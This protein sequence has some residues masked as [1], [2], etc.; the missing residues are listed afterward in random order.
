MKK[1]MFIAVMAMFALVQSACN[2]NTTSQ[3]TSNYSTDTDTHYQTRERSVEYNT[4]EG[5]RLPIEAGSPDLS[6]I[7]TSRLASKVSNHALEMHMRKS[8]RCRNTV[9]NV[10]GVGLVFLFDYLTKETAKEKRNK[11]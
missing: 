1:H 4:S 8:P 7:E 9:G 10:L 5:H 3:Q 11:R 6:S 2:E